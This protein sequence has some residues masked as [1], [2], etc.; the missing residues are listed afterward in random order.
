MQPQTNKPAA[1][2]AADDVTVIYSNT[3]GTAFAVLIPTKDAERPS[4]PRDTPER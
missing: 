1:E 4:S 2:Q 3:G